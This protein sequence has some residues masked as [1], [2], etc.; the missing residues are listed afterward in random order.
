MSSSWMWRR[1]TVL[2]TNVLEE[3]ITSILRVKRI[4]ELSRRLAVSNYCYSVLHL[5][6]TVN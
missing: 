3:L 1:V 6:V 2:R 4:S 5:L